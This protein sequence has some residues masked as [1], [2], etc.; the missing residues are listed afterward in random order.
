MAASTAMATPTVVWLVASFISIVAGGT[1]RFRTNGIGE[2]VVI[3]SSMSS[4]CCSKPHSGGRDILHAWNFFMEWF[5]THRGG[6]R[7]DGPSSPPRP[8][9]L[10]I[11][12]DTSEAAHVTNIYEEFVARGVKLLLGPYGS[13]LTQ[14]AARMM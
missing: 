7:V 9:E 10:L 8:L 6:I 5:E 12:D 1:F 14:P 11:V 3:A 13:T 2:P 4:D